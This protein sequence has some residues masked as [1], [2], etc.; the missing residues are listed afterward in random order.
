M[1]S[2]VGCGDD[3]GSDAGGTF[4]PKQAGVLTV[5]HVPPGA[6]VLGWS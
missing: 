6:G 1:L 2:A 5:D 4:T 3:S